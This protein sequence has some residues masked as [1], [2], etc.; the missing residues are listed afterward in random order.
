VVVGGSS[1]SVGAAGGWVLGGGHSS[2][3]PQYGLGVD[4]ESKF[5]ASHYLIPLLDVIQ[6]EI[7]TPDGKLRTANQ[8]QN[9][10]LFWALRG[11]GPGFGVCCH[12]LCSVAY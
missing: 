12:S 7:V 11:G 2:L 8:F 1:Y 6:F 4:S 3:S 5:K 10:D 9:Q